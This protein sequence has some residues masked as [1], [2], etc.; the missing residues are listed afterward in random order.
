MIIE[1]IFST[2]DLTGRPNFAPMGML[3]GEEEMIVRPFRNTHTCANLL[4]TG[5]GVV[6]VTDDVL[7]FVEA[8]LG[9]PLLPHFPA[10]RVPGVV[11][12]GACYWRELEVTALEGNEERAEITCRVVHRGWQ[13]DFLGFNRARNAIVELAILA[14]RLHLL[15]PES[16]MEALERAETI[17]RKTGGETEMES[18]ARIQEYVKRWRYGCPG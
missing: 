10:R 14:T 2:L 4:A 15:D 16:V 8:A 12:Q 17:V 11:F 3:W 18:F 6:N 9:D 1:V 5:Y 13:R 7:A